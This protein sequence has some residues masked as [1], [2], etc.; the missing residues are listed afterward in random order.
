MDNPKKAKTYL[1]SSSARV[2]INVKVP[3]KVAS[4][5]KCKTRKISVFNLILCST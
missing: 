1:L 3:P 2:K 4:K 5:V